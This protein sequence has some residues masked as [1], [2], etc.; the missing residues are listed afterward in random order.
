M[1]A[2]KV[3]SIA[4]GLLV[5]MAIGSL[6]AEAQ[7]AYLHLGPQSLYPTA[8]PDRNADVPLVMRD[9]IQGIALGSR[10]LAVNSRII[11]GEPAPTD[12]YPWV[13]SLSLKGIDH[14]DGHFCGGAFFTPTWVVTAAHCVNRDSVDKI[15]VLGGTN[16]LGQGGTI[17][18][19]DQV[20]VHEKYDPDTSDFD[21]ALL[22]LTKPYAGRTVRLLTAAAAARIARPGDLAIVAGWG[23]TTEGGSISTVMRR[24]TVQFVSNQVCNGLS[25]YSGSI[26]GQMVCAG[27]A[28]GGKDSCQGDSGGPLIVADGTGSYLLA[29]IVSFGEGCGRPN[30]FGVYTS[31]ATVHDWII[32]HARPARVAARPSA[33]GTVQAST[34]PAIRNTTSSRRASVIR[35]FTQGNKKRGGKIVAKRLHKPARAD[36]RRAMTLREPQF[37]IRR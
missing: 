17:H 19:V 26:T 12:A 27:F 21:V 31:V 35:K 28:E 11:G 34:T 22:H 2:G 23:L 10:L 25:S 16:I 4:A 15:Q 1:G 7:Q 36:A 6:P 8:K 14:Q 3:R 24:V 13:A 5:T 29:G 37:V 33:P 30:K 9:A 18:L 32:D 20:I